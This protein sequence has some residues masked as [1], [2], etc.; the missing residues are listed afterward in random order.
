MNSYF[1][2]EISS[3]KPGH[4]FQR[5]GLPYSSESTPRGKE[6]KA[7]SVLAQFYD[8]VNL[9]APVLGFGASQKGETQMGSSLI[10]VTWPL[11][12]SSQQV[13]LPYSIVSKDS[14]HAQSLG[15]P[16]HGARG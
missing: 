12:C 3:W 2:K 9:G 7:P 4:I 15:G 14:V 5:E 6:P 1:R 13:K 8:P 16:G 10:K 11:R